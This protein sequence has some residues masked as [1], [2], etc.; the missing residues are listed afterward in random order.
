MT[1]DVPPKKIVIRLFHVY[2][3]YGPEQVLKD[4]CFDV[5][6]NDFVVIRGPSGAGKSTL[7]KLLYLK[8]V[9]SDGQ[10]LVD[11]LNLSH[12]PRRQ[13]PYLRRK[14]GIILQDNLF[15]SNRTVFDNVA[16]ALQ[17][18]GK[19]HRLVKNKVANVLRTVGLE[20]KT[21]TL[22]G[23]LCRVEKQKLAFARAIVVDPQILLADEP[24]ECLDE[25]ASLSIL[26][27]LTKY[28]HRGATV[29][30]TSHNE[31]LFQHH[32]VKVL[33]LEKGKL[34]FPDGL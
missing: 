18:R 14:F 2:K 31:K 25:N 13:R 34:Q 4:I 26:A 15:I 11:D 30:V 21:N 17:V 27:L 33:S 5:A 16:L 12:L 29:I 22:P 9:A 23:A 7:L 32:S 19:R 24:V 10:I 1:G 20:D 6:K 28:H 8:E 3:S